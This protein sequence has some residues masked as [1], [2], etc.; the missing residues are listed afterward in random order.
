MN[1][2]GLFW[3]QNIGIIL[4]LKMIAGFEF[5]MRTLNLKDNKWIQSY[6]CKRNIVQLHVKVNKKFK[7]KNSG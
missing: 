4:N 6:D 3:I 5:K 2:L 1:G 7:F